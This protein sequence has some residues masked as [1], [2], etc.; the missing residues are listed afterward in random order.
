MELLK[1][2]Y[3]YMLGF[4]PGLRKD[5]EKNALKKKFPQVI[6]TVLDNYHYL[7]SFLLQNLE[8]SSL[9]DFKGK[10]KGIKIALRHSV[11]TVL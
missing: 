3:I 4:Q 7:F 8:M 5:L 10:E 9:S 11:L 1:T 6:L 2:I